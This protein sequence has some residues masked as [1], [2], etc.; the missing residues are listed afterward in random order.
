MRGRGYQ[1]HAQLLFELCECSRSNSGNLHQIFNHSK[2]TID[3]FKKVWDCTDCIYHIWW[4]NAAI[5]KLMSEESD[6][7]SSNI[8]VTMESHR[9]NAYIQGYK[10]TRQWFPG[11]FLIHFAGVY[12]P[13]KMIEF[14]NMIE[15]G[16]I[17]RIT[18]G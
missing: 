12:E 18:M 17:P 9:F 16:N 7:C 13:N 14:M 5:C 6:D 15:S 8:E 10:G 2:W 3:F 11:D 4:E 1:L